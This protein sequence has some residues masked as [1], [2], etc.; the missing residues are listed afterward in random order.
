MG[1]HRAARDAQGVGD[2]GFGLVQVVPQHE[3]LALSPGK[4]TDLA[5]DPTQLLSIDDL[6]LGRVEN[7]RGRSHAGNQYSESA[8]LAKPSA[9]AVD[10]ACVQIGDACGGI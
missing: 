1:L 3:D 10:H 5:P 8:A 7:I 9:A 6:L 2:L 4:L